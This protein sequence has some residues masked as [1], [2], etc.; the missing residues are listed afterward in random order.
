VEIKTAGG[1]EKNRKKEGEGKEAITLQKGE[2][3]KKKNIA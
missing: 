1:R 3:G 2:K